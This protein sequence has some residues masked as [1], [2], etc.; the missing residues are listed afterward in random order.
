MTHSDAFD[1]ITAAINYPMFVVTT[2]HRAE[3]SG[4]LV[5]FATQTSI[6]PPRFSWVSRRPTTRTVLP[7]TPNILLCI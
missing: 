2:R 6:D 3:R 4:C 5:G 1:E 7:Q